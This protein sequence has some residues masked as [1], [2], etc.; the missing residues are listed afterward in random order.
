[1]IRT[2]IAMALSAALAAAVDRQTETLSVSFDGVDLVF[3]LQD[4]WLLGLN[5]ASVDGQVLTSAETLLRPLLVQ[6]FGDHDHLAE[7]LRLVSVAERGEEVVLEL[8]LIGRPREVA[9]ADWCVMKGEAVHTELF[10]FAHLRLPA[11]I[12]TLAAQR[13]RLAALDGA[14][15]LG[16]LRWILAPAVHAAGDG[17][18]WRG[19][20]HHYELD[21][22]VGEA[23]NTVYELGTWELDGRA[24]G[25]TLVSPRYRG[26][27][28]IVNTLEPMAGGVPGATAATFTTTEILPGAAGD[29]PVVSPAVPGP[30]GIADRASGMAHRHGAWIAQLQRG[31]GAHWIDFQYR[32]Q[33]A[34]AAFYA[35]MDAIRSLTEVFPGDAVVS[36]TDVLL[37]PLGRD[38]ATPRKLHL[39]LVPPG[40]LPEH[41]WRTRWQELDRSCRAMLQRE[42]DFV[43]SEPLPSTGIGLDYA[44]TNRIGQ[45]AGQAEDMERLGLKRVLVHH[46]GWFNGRGLRQKETPHPLQD[47]LDHKQKPATGGD[48]SIHDYAAQSPAT[49]EAWRELVATLHQQDMEY[50]VWITGMVYHTGPAVRDLGEAGFARNQPGAA[51]SAGYPGRPEGSHRHFGIS[52]REPAIAEWWHGRME[53]AATELGIDGFWADSFQNMFMS[54]MNY[55]HPDWAPQVREWWAWISAQTRQGRG[56]MSESTS[57]P[58][59]SCSIEVGGAAEDFAGIEWTGHYI[60]R[61][62]RG[63][64]LPH[65]GSPAADR[66]YFRGLANK[67]VWVPHNGG[68]DEIPSYAALNHAYLA[69]LDDMRRGYQLDDGSVLWLPESGHDSGVLWAFNPRNLPAGVA[70]TDL[71]GTAL[72][73][74]P[75]QRVLR[76]NAM[77]LRRAFSLRLPEDF[78]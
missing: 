49:A 64:K 43:P 52:L 15:T 47:C 65:H 54:Q 26:L 60:C 77:D 38:W 46:P 53:V 35:S 28:G 17:W 30:Q 6:R 25:T 74:I 9:A 68:H 69:V 59:L 20:R 42:L 33:G 10:A 36:Q 18:R 71:A 23:V 78:E 70:A 57:D 14:D 37:A 19:W 50:W 12:M 56:W 31:G 8:A 1:M 39:A 27:G 76:V 67:L 21:L 45:L 55:Q 75:E 13:E 72:A 51:V 34:F 7:G 24:A 41:E 40:G 2:L 22:A 32:P 44:W 58:G 62:F 48:C 3:T 16:R 5:Q 73:T 66:G 4:D 11:E 61:W 63:R 29:G